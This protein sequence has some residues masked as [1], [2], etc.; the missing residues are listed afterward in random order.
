MQSVALRPREARRK[1]LPS[2]YRTLVL[3]ADGI[4]VARKIVMAA[5]NSGMSVASVDGL[6]KKI[7]LA[8]GAVLSLA[9]WVA[10]ASVLQFRDL[11]IERLRHAGHPE[12]PHCASK[13]TGG[14]V[15]STAVLCQKRSSGRGIVMDRLME[16]LGERLPATQSPPPEAG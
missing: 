7:L 6:V 9:A 15:A 5:R 14:P 13:R 12:R 10:V 2:S 16:L 8:F 1:S 11:A 4:P 3:N